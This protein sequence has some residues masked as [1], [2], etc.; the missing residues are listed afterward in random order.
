M[1]LTVRK[2]PS[3]T[4]PASVAMILPPSAKRCTRIIRGTG[5]RSTYTADLV[6]R[7]SIPVPFSTSRPKAGFQEVEGADVRKRRRKT[8]LATHS[9]IRKTA[10]N[11]T[12]LVIHSNSK[13][14]Y[15]IGSNVVLPIFQ[16]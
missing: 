13:I 5:D 10:T 15:V 7:A 8:N 4:L 11:A 1:L 16:A 2:W 9:T 12:S 14:V 3:V 6:A